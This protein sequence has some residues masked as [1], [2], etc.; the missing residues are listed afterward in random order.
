MFWSE[1]NNNLGNA[2]TTH[3]IDDA[4]PHAK[5]FFGALLEISNLFSKLARVNENNNNELL[6]NSKNMFSVTRDNADVE[7]NNFISFT[8]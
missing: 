5:I 6:Q 4:I 3:S 2:V 7:I 8:M 1:T